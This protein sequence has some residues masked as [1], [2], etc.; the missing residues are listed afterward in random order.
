VSIFAPTEVADFLEWEVPSSDIPVRQGDLLVKK[1]GVSARV[2]EVVV[3]ITADCDIARE[4]HE[5]AI[6]A[7]RVISFADYVRHRW[8]HSAYE[9]LV[10]G[11]L[12]ELTNSFNKSRTEGGATAANVSA[13]GF[14]Q[15]LERDAPAIICADVIDEKCRAKAVAAA[16]SAQI[17]LG[18]KDI[19][20]TNAP[21]DCYLAY[22]AHK[23][24][25][26]PAQARTQIL[27]RARE[28]LSTLPADVFFVSQLPV[29]G[30]SSHLVLLREL[31]AINAELATASA[32]TA[33]Q[34]NG[35]LRI[36]RLRPPY[37]YALSQQFGLMFSRVGLPDV[38]EKA[39]REYLKGFEV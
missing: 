32:N 11:E 23:N 9:T 18:H 22:Q 21:F 31:V 5:G 38:Y 29:S 8:A 3:V 20:G 14:A 15:W 12:Q 17:L 39:K 7:L 35:Y 24:K 34:N 1:D 6:A 4:K 30:T 26:E 16:E 19:L 36:G 10:E 33:R 2:T 28:S 13:D 27:K 37:K 25:V